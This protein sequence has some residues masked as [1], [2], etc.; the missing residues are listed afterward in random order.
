MEG[1]VRAWESNDPAD[2]GR[3]FAEDAEYFT[4]PFR[5]PQRGRDEIVADW[6]DRKDDPG[7]WRFNYEILDVAGD[8]GFVHGKTEYADGPTTFANLWVIRLDAD[9]QCLEFT[10]WWMEVK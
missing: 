6:I 2:I 10:E 3:L 8:L 1:Y 7:T 9:G 4:A 5:E